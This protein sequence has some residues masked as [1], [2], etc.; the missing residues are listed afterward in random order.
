MLKQQKHRSD[1]KRKVTKVY[2]IGDLV[3]ILKCL[4]SNEG[5]G[6]D[7]IQPWITISINESESSESDLNDDT[8]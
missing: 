7:R 4:P 2:Q 1:K 6:A 8:G 5:K 3:K